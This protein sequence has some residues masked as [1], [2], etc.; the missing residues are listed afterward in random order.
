MISP[1]NLSG[2]TTNL[3]LSIS[4]AQYFLQPSHA[5]RI[6]SGG[7]PIIYTDRTRLRKEAVVGKIV[8]DWATRCEPKPAKM[9]D[10]GTLCGNF[11]E[12]SLHGG[13]VVH[14]DCH[15]LCEAGPLALLVEQLGGKAINESGKRVLDLAVD[16]PEVHK[17]ITLIAGSGKDVDKIAN[18]LKVLE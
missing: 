6:P 18:E 10:T 16:D 4:A 3:F 9:F 13:I 14:F 5:L 12:V 2:V 1:S 15:L 8:C 7:V 17:S 11:N